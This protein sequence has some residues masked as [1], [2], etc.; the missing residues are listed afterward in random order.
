[1]QYNDPIRSKIRV[2]HRH[3]SAQGLGRFLPF[4]KSATPEQTKPIKSLMIGQHILMLYL[5]FVNISPQHTFHGRAAFFSITLTDS[6]NALK[7]QHCINQV[8]ITLFF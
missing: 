1:M 3:L 7:E 4:L 6:N 2:A 8:T 5:F